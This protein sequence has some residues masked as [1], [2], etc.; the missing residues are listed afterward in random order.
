MNRAF[1]WPL[2][3]ALLIIGLSSI[4]S[5]ALPD[6][7]WLTFD[8]L[9]HFTEYGILGLLVTHAWRSCRSHLPRFS[10]RI[11]LPSSLFAA[12]DELYQMLIPG[13][14]CSIQDWLADVAGIIVGSLLYSLVAG[15]YD[16]ATVH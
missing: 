14:L 11:L 12:L 4:P 7:P 15:R 1:L 5:R 6:Y 13:R 9:L 8:K 3:Y 10:I 2:L 16:Q